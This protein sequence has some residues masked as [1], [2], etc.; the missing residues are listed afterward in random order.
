M[1]A[2]RPERVP[3]ARPAIFPTVDTSWQGK[4][5]QRTSTG[6]TVA[7]SMAV[8]S[9]RFGASGQWWEKTRATGSLISENQ[10][11]LALKTSSTA[12]SSPP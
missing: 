9:P 10:T 8:M 4:P 12:R 5:P 6:G 11:V 1:C 3:G 7:R 2:H